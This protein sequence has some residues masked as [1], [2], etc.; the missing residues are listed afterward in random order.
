MR[1]ASLSR[2]VVAEQLTSLTHEVEH[3]HTH[4]PLT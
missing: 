3:T 1:V 2:A 4:T